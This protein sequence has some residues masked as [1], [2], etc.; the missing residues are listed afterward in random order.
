[1]STCEKGTWRFQIQPLPDVCAIL[2]CFL[3]V[4][5]R[6]SAVLNSIDKTLLYIY[7]YENMNI[8]I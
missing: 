2:Q 4:M 5:L 8:N 1:M 3:M 6:N 7:I